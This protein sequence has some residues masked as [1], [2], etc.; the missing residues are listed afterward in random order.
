[1]ENK[2]IFDLGV[3]SEYW[4]DLATLRNY[5]DMRYKVTSMHIYHYSD[6][7][8]SDRKHTPKGKAGNTAKLADNLTRARSRVQELALC[9]PW[10]WFVTFTLDKTK[11]DRHDLAKF[12]KDLGQFIRDWRK[13]QGADVKY[14]LIP[15]R[16]KDG[17]WHMH[18]FLMGLPAE[19]LRRFLLSDLLPAKI[20][21]RIKEGKSIYT[22]EA[23]ARR[24][25]F[26]DIEPI[27]NG[28]A[29][30]NYILKYITKDT[31]RSISALGAHM[32]YASQG[33]EGAQVIYRDM[34][35]KQIEAP[36]YKN[37]YCTVKWYD[38]IEAAFACFEEG[39][40][41]DN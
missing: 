39:G 22:W 17:A 41:I 25:G 32:F 28:E 1:M 9:N 14:L 35:D 19:H 29:A 31:A 30:G 36:D 20:R 8:A 23:Y 7:D 40:T 18:G 37:D 38:D 11:Y 26:A 4:H 13:R 24:F 21:A 16:H 15:E 6:G 2:D 34:L 27:E 12:S 33:L 3:V 10:Q 5:A